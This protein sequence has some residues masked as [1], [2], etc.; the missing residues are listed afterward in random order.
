MKTIKRTLTLLAVL[1]C[2]FAISIGAQ[3]ASKI[4]VNMDANLR[5]GPGKDFSIYT[6]VKEG[7]SLTFLGGIEEDERGIDWYEVSYKGRD[8]WISSKCGT[9]VSKPST[10]AKKRVITTADCN[11]RK[12]PGLSYKIYV[13]VQE[14]S[15]F[16]YLGKSKRD[17]RDVKWYKIS[18]YGRSLWVSSKNSYRKNVS[19]KYVITNEECNLRRGPGLD[20]SVYTSV[21]EGTVIKYLG[22]YKRDDREVKW[23]KIKYKGKTLWISSKTCVLK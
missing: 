9:K 13:T 18:Y 17:D 23:Y 19:S 10:S 14:G 8:L 2:F 7:K 1:V 11:L 4:Y 3:A 22:K 16:K 15:S 12:G 20:Y 21:Y 6:S 5:K